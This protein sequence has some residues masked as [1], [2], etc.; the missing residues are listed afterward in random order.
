MVVEFYTQLQPNNGLA[1]YLPALRRCGAAVLHHAPHLGPLCPATSLHCPCALPTACHATSPRAPLCP[2]N[3]S[4]CS[5][6]GKGDD[7]T[8]LLGFETDVN[9]LAFDEGEACV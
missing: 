6:A 3:H 4:R 1:K 9:R 7:F 8:G 5:L 2:A